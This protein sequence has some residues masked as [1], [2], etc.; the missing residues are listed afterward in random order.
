MT[1]DVLKRR[2]QRDSHSGAGTWGTSSSRSFARLRRRT[3]S[4]SWCVTWSTE[5]VRWSDAGSC[6]RIST[7]DSFDSVR[8]LS[9]VPDSFS[10]VG[11]WGRLG[12][13]AP[14][15]RSSIRF[16]A[17]WGS[18]T[19]R[20]IIQPDPRGRSLKDAAP[21]FGC[22]RLWNGHRQSQSD[23]FILLRSQGRLLRSRCAFEPFRRQ[24]NSSRRENESCS[25]WVGERRVRGGDTEVTSRS[26]YVITNRKP[27]GPVPAAPN[28]GIRIGGF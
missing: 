14:M 25:L 3:K 4:V 27:N 2:S 11:C 20:S 12:F 24:R 13:N 6:I 23:A 16:N 21:T 19:V 17:G 28:D 9:D 5:N 10:G 1:L 22:G 15:L 26:T 18:R 7:S 8:L